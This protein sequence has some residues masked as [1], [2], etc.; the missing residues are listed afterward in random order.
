M[1]AVLP[2]DSLMVIYLDGSSIVILW[3]SVLGST[4]SW[5]IRASLIWIRMSLTMF[6]AARGAL[7]DPMGR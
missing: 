2:Y 6:V 4:R 3:T 7:V 5:V 1:G